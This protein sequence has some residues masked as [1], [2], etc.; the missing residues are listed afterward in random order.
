[1]KHLPL[2]LLLLAALLACAALVPAAPARAGFTG[3]GVEVINKVA[4]VLQ[5][6]D[7]TYVTMVGHV[8]RQLDGPH[9]SFRDASGEMMVRIDDYLWEDVQADPKTLVKLIGQVQADAIRTEVNVQYISVQ[10]P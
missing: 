2:P 5:A 6:P 10:E 4:E 7:G 9:Y 3:P 8:L 1:M